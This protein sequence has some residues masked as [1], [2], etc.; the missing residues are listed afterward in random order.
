MI[1]GTPPNPCVTSVQKG[2]SKPVPRHLDARKQMANLTLQRLL[3]LHRREIQDKTGLSDE[4][5]RWGLVVMVT[6]SPFRLGRIYTPSPSHHCR[7]E[8]WV[9]QA[10][11]SDT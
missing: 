3:G 9:T 1:G 4:Q 6:C 7:R 11:D 10:G 8:Q 2:L 5:E